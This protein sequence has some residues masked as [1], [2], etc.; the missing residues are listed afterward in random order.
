MNKTQKNLRDL[1]RGMQRFYTNRNLRKLG[2]FLVAVI[3][4]LSIPLIPFA[5][6]KV[7]IGG[8]VKYSILYNFGFNGKVS[9]RMD[10]NV[11][12]RNG[13]GRGFTVPA[14]VRNTYTSLQRGYLSTFSAGWK[15][16]STANK[17]SW[18][19]YSFT[20]TDRFALPYSVTGKAAYIAANQNLSN[21][22]VSTITTAPAKVGALDETVSALSVT[23]AITYNATNLDTNSKYLVYA[24]GPLSA[25]VFRPSKSAY[26]LLGVQPTPSAGVVTLTTLYTNKF[27]AVPPTGA[28]MFMYTVAVN[29]TTGEMSAGSA[30]LSAVH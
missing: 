9:G 24:T 25:G 4:F 6:G 18:N 16:L 10:G 12:M 26:R 13:R 19:A 27:G 22:A 21:I 20:K 17:N 28:K 29:S 7:V 5:M 8:V 15:A 30:I 3:A 14:L 2:A 1:K 11:L 23:L